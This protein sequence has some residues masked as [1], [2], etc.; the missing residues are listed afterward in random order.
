MISIRIYYFSNVTHC[1]KQTEKSMNVVSFF[2]P[3]S[4]GDAALLI[5]FVMSVN[6]AM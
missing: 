5:L 6:N 1:Q 3:L 4:G 2:L